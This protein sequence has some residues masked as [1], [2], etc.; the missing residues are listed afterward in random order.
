MFATLGEI[1]FSLFA[2]E[3]ENL[4][5]RLIVGVKNRGSLLCKVP[6]Y[7]TRLK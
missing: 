2:N 3:K 4:Q 6:F 1:Y 5:H 7:A